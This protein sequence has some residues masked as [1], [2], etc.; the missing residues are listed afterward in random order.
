L[1][2]GIWGQHLAP[3]LKEA[4]QVDQQLYQIRLRPGVP[5]QAAAALLNSAWLA[6]Q[7]ELQGRVNFGEGVLWLAGYEVEAL[8]LPDPRYLDTEQSERLANHF[9]A[10]AARPV[11]PTLAEELT[12]PDRRALNDTVFN[13]LE[14]TETEAVVLVDTLLE[15]VD[16]RQTQ[17]QSR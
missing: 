14:L 16:A 15:R 12:R 2:K 9:R 1:P 5:L 3:H 8:L 6:L 10:L 17:A 4:L 11:A 7:L 13:L